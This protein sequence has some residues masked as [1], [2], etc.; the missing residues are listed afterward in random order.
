ME[1]Y[2][3]EFVCRNYIPLLL[4]KERDLPKMDQD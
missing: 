2:S 3:F 4:N 1:M